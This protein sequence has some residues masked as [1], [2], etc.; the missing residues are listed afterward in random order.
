MR[1][2]WL[3]KRQFCP[4]LSDITNEDIKKLANQLK[5]ESDKETLT[6]ILEW[7]HRNINYWMERGILESPWWGL[8]LIYSGLVL[9]AFVIFGIVL[10]FFISKILG[11]A[12][13]ALVAFL[14]FWLLL[15]TLYN[16]LLIIIFMMAL[17]LP[18]YKYI[19]LISNLFASEVPKTI[20]IS[21]IAIGIFTV[22][23]LGLSYRYLP[24]VLQSKNFISKL[25]LIAIA[26]ND[27]FKMKLSAEKVLTY[28][29]AICRDYALFTASLLLNL[30]PEVYFA[31]FFPHVAPGI[32][33]KD[34]IYMLDQKLPIRTLDKWLEVWNKKKVTLYKLEK[35]YTDN[36]IELKFSKVG[37]YPRNKTKDDNKNDNNYEEHL[38]KLEREINRMFGLNK[39]LEKR[40]FVEI[41]LKNF[42][43][44][45]ENDEIV[46][47]S[48][49]RLLKNKI[50]AELCGN[51]SRIS[52]I[53][54]L[55]QNNDII[56][57]CFLNS[58]L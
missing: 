9:S 29:L 50:E 12:M 23:Y 54:L 1:I 13:F 26:I 3:D 40:K 52:G 36:S 55:K 43:W 35:V 58:S 53:E 20:Y 24:N 49:L 34:K 38:Q 25:L 8:G 32:R 6:N 41:E 10:Y 16:I 33:I 37:Q 31:T 47:Y 46:Q 56:L 17:A 44:Y 22:L 27:T 14:V 45:Y 4:N 18:I 2:K 57:K 42:V 11:I 5:G 39:T 7:Q 30:Y 51:V 28:K 15:A 48:I 21:I 19:E